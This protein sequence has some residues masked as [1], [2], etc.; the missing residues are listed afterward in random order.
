ML[1]NFIQECY[2]KEQIKVT[3]IKR[4]LEIS[5]RKGQRQD[6]NPQS[7]GPFSQT[8]QMIELRCEYLSLRC[9]II[10]VPVSE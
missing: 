7:S 3:S 1:Q 8:G 2:R 9:I 4:F 5:R 6:S 10:H